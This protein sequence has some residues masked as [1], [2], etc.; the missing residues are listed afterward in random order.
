M[1]R[2]FVTWWPAAFVGGLAYGFSPFTAATANA[3]L[4]LLFQAVP[5][6]I[7]LFVDRFFRHAQDLAPVVRRRDRALLRRAVLHLDRGLRLAGRHDV[8][9]GGPRR[10]LRAVEA[11]AARPARRLVTMVG[12]AADRGRPRRRLRRLGGR[13]RSRAHH[14]SCAAGHGDRGGDRRPARPRRPDPRPTLHLRTRRVGRLA[15][16]AAATPTGT[17]C[18]T[19]PSRTG[20]TSACRS[21]SPWWSAASLL[22]RK[23]LALFCSA[24][25]VIALILSMGSGCTVDGHRTGIPLPFIVIAHLPL[26]RQQRRLTVG[27]LFLAVRRACCSPCCSTPR[28]RR[29]PPTGRTGRRGAPPC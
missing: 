21:S 2:R 27:D 10:R 1:A 11:R 3:H 16:R 23:R 12:C 19:H 24:M 28:T 6:L 29:W 25:G 14:R 17:S 22:R 18:S 26:A 5:P 7:I 15:R 13:G 4:F 8:R 9:R 20:P